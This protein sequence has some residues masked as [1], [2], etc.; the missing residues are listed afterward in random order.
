[1]NAMFD[2]EL[3]LGMSYILP[4]LECVHMLIKVAK[5]R[6]VFVCFCRK[7]QINTTQVLQVIL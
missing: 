5:S 4:L 3:I 6:D 7:R 2:V 1:M